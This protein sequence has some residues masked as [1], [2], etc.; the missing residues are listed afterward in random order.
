[1]WSTTTLT[2]IWGWRKWEGFGVQFRR[3]DYST[4]HVPSSG[5]RRQELSRFPFITLREPSLL[6]LGNVHRYSSARTA[7][8]FVFISCATPN[9][10]RSYDLAVEFLSGSL[11]QYERREAKDQE[12][13]L[14]RFCFSLAWATAVLSRDTRKHHTEKRSRKSLHLFGSTSR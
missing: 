8:A 14:A 3:R 13:S 12:S 5:L 10:I 6:W 11:P 9:R 2:R 4:L 7:R 1:M